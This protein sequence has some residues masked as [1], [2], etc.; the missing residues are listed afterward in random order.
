M[1]VSDDGWAVKALNE[2]EW[3]EDE[4]WANIWLTDCIARI[5]PATGTVKCVHVMSNGWI[6][7][8]QGAWLYGVTF[9][10]SC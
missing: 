8:L 4:I 2:L 5:D 10:K 9:G 6:A 7:C 3:V 1:Q